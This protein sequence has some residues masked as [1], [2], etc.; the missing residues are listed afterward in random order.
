MVRTILLP[1]KMTMKLDKNLILPWVKSQNKNNTMLHNAKDFKS[2]VTFIA[3][4]IAMITAYE[5]NQRQEYEMC[6]IQI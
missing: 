3:R 5:G 6:E 1:R 2:I 4:S